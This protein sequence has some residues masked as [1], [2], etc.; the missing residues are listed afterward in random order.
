M[1]EWKNTR[2]PLLPLEYHI[3][4]VEAH[5]MPDGRVYLYGSWDQYNDNKTYCSHQYRVFSTDDMK[6]WKDH[7]IS[8]DVKEV[9]WF[10]KEV[11]D[12]EIYSDWNPKNFSP[13]QKKISRMLEKEYGTADKK[14]LEELMPKS[15]P[16][17]YAPDAIHKNG[18]YY[19]YF[20]GS[21]N[22]EGV[23]VS[24]KPEGP[25]RNPVKLPCEGIDPAVFV[26]DDGKAYYYWG[27]FRANG[28]R[29]KDNMV[30]LEGDTICRRILTEE[31]HGMIEGCSMRKRNGIYYLV[32]ACINDY[33]NAVRLAYATSDTP[34]GKF[35][36]RGTIIENLG[37]DPGCVNNHGSIEEINGQWYVFYHRSSRNSIIHR[38]VCV[39]PIYFRED[40][41]IEEV[42][43]TS[44][45]AGEPFVL[46]EKIMGYQACELKGKIYIDAVAEAADRSKE[47]L[48][49]I[50]SGDAA[51]F[52]YVKSERDFRELQIKAVGNGTIEVWMSDRKAGEIEVKNGQQ[53]S[54]KISMKSGQYEL[55]LLFRSA[56]NL[57][58]DW[59]ILR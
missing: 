11:S 49:N 56:E 44:Q 12:S 3:P 32:Y 23:A 5:V 37:C 41:S 57:E 35:T 14:K 27:Q 53:I 59:I 46:D 54:R 28:A 9:P 25:F 24:N 36:K 38:R 33:G 1:M 40:G 10:H 7:G 26:D 18:K 50:V 55:K 51:I 2:N 48:V 45:G 58:V 16:L 43:M 13:S 15:E 17:I 4:D 6:N 19:L 34:L 42:K 8:F 22:S 21:D 29:L 20:C 39:E 30:E 31:E 52:R 47:A